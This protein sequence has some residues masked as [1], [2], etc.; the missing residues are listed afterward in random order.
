MGGGAGG[1]EAAAG[2]REAVVAVLCRGGRVLVIRRGPGGRLPGYWALPSGTV[3]TGE[4]QQDALVREMREEV[5]LTVVPAAKVW[6]SRSSGGEFLV[7]WW[8]AGV[9]GGEVV[10]DPREVAG[11]RWVTPPEFL[12][13]TPVLPADC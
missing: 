11:S 13:L 9:G 6:E 8:T 10:P 1:R 5:G 7:H 12:A 4:S 3:E 2:G